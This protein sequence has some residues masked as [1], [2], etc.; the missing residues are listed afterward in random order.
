MLTLNA[1]VVLAGGKRYV[2]FDID[3]STEFGDEVY[4]WANAYEKKYSNYLRFDCRIGYRT[5]LKRFSQEIAFDVQNL[6][7]HKNILLQKFDPGSGEIKNVFQIGIFPMI[8]WKL[9]F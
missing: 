6:T 9:E 8:T 2:P 7:S 5:N 3:R 1:K 4:D